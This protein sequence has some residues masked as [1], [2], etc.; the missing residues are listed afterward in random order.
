MTDIA[1]LD[2]LIDE[3]DAT[4]G[5]AARALVAS[6]SLATESLRVV[7]I[8][9]AELLKFADAAALTSFDV[10]DRLA[11]DYAGPFANLTKAP[12]TISRAAYEAGVSGTR[13]LISAV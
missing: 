11:S 8:A 12:N 5:V 10:Y 4:S 3:A 6:M 13:K 2:E 9:G 7:K 1:E